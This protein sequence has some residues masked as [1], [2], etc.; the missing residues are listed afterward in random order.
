MLFFGVIR[1]NKG[2]PVLLKAM[3]RLPECR[4]TIV[5]ESERPCYLDEINALIAALPAGQVDLNA[6]YIEEKDIAGVFD[7]AQ[8]L[9]LP[10]TEFASQSG[11]LHQAV[12]H[13]RPVVATSEGG[14]GE[15]VREWGIGEVVAAHD[16]A[17]LAV[18]I[19]RAL[20]PDVFRAAAAATVR[21][22]Q[23]HTWPR[24]AEATLDAYR[25]V[26]G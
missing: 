1:P 12:A 16:E 23:D 6:H 18:G 9:I 19:R 13:G 15:S 14:L 24:M 21:V 25:A 2:L 7:R 11:V 17:A 8:L 22:R 4:L 10:Y 20:Q 5:G 3:R 26:A